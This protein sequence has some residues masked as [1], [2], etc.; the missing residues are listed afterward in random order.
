M[1]RLK[2]EFNLKIEENSIIFN[3]LRIKPS[4]WL[5]ESL[6]IAF[7][8][9]LLS[10]K[11][12]SELIVTPILQELRKINNRSISIFSGLNLDVQ[13]DSDL[14]GECD[15]MI[16]RGNNFHFIDAPVISIVEAKKQDIDLGLAQCIAQMI[17][18]YIFN[19]Q[20]GNSIKTVFGAVTTGEI[21]QFM[22]LEQVNEN[23]LVTIEKRRYYIDSVESILGAIQQVI[24]FY[25]ES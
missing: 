10:E 16:T 3:E 5:Q 13:S 22:K 21:W 9:P 19:E 4:N 12:R 20:E 11:A 15:F 7:D 24:D 17:G 8:S 6:D 25:K 2:Q 23:Y 18:A 1:K 14:N